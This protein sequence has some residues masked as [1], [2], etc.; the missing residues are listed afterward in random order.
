MSFVGGGGKVMERGC[1]LGSRVLRLQR[2]SRRASA[3][4]DIPGLTCAG[5]LFTGPVRHESI[6]AKKRPARKNPYGL[7]FGSGR[8]RP[9]VTAKNCPCEG[10]ENLSR[11]S[12]VN[13]GATSDERHARRCCIESARFSLLAAMSSGLVVVPHDFPGNV[14]TMLARD[15]STRAQQIQHR[16]RLAE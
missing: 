5:R 10:A 4:H 2:G 3:P 7:R 11:G 15:E 14:V 9:R 16:S 8:S 12:E 6:V 13:I 1:V